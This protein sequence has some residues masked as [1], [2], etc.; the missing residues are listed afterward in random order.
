[1][2]VGANQQ[3]A[4]TM[5]NE[6]TSVTKVAQ[7]TRRCVTGEQAINL[8]R[9]I[10]PAWLDEMPLISLEHQPR[11]KWFQALKAAVSVK[12][13]RDGC[14]LLIFF[15]CRNPVELAQIRSDLRVMRDLCDDGKKTKQKEE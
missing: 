3:Q 9:L 6:L 4:N 15:P 2:A 11:L 8:L 12:Y 7:K 14:W 5:Q 10:E 13:C 1:V